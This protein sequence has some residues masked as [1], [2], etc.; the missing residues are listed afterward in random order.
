MYKNRAVIPERL[1]E[2]VLSW[3]HSVHQGVTNMITRAVECFW[4]PRFSNDIA[5]KRDKCTY[6]NENAPSQPQDPPVS[7]ANPE[8]PFQHLWSDIFE[9][10]GNQFI[11]IVDA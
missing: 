2:P 10:K 4:W 9:I 1:S 8:Y 6:C 3:L 7:I 5:R 11:V